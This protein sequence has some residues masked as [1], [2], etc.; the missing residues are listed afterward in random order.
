MGDQVSL[1]EPGAVDTDMWRGALDEADQTEAALSDE[2]R[3]LYAKHIAGLKKTIP[4]M[5][6]QAAPVDKI[7]AAIAKALLASRPRARYVVGLDSKIQLGIKSALPTSVTDAAL[8]KVM[9]QPGK[10]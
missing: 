5:Q 8:G 6:K 9:K 4:T 7:T 3:V 2:H 1:I 10:G